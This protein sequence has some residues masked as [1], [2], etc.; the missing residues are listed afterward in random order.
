MYIVR[1][2]EVNREGFSMGSTT[3]PWDSQ[4]PCAQQTANRRE[5]ASGGLGR[6]QGGRQA[7]A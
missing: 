4:V 6:K 3:L 2:R 5:E 1:A 7:E